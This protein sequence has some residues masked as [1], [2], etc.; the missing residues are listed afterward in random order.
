MSRL[1]SPGPESLPSSGR[2][3]WT[4]PSNIALIKYWGKRGLQLPMNA[5]LSVTLR[6]SVSCVTLDFR[7]VGNGNGGVDFTFEGR[8]HP[9]FKKRV[10]SYLD[11]IRQWFP[12]LDRLWLTIDS[13]NTFPHS[14]GIASSASFMSALALCICQLED[15]WLKEPG[16][17]FFRKASFMARL[18]SGSASRSVYSPMAAW[19]KHPAIKDSSDQYAVPVRE[20]IPQTF[21]NL[22][23]TI[24]IVDAGTK[25]VSSSKGH[26]LMNNHPYAQNRLEQA[27]SNFQ[28]IMDA[29]R[30]NQWDTFASITENEALSLHAMML[31]SVPG[32]SLLKQQTLEIIERVKTFRKEHNA[33]IT[34]T[35]DA[36]P[37]VHLLYPKEEKE[38]IWPF[39]Q[40]QIKPLTENN[41]IIADQMG[42]GPNGKVF[43][44]S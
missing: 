14:A 26:Q 25:K 22:Q 20:K 24:A 2:V 41:K 35:L 1:F 21:Q 10:V 27:Q 16:D 3:Q 33:M 28:K 23:D 8:D 40:K 39:I 43:A 6:H 37:N 31:S 29:I 13:G 44:N 30:N 12:F 9:V 15:Y 7:Q 36:G 11:S 5:S 34:F 42:D 19:G 4:S 32:F 17:D 38:T 18:G